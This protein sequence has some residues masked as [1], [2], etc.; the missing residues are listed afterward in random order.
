MKIILYSIFLTLLSFQ[1]FAA[2]NFNC[3]AQQSGVDPIQIQLSDDQMQINILN[4]NHY[5][6][7]LLNR[8]LSN[9]SLLTFEGSISAC[10]D[11]PPGGIPCHAMR[12]VILKMDPTLAN[13]SSV[14]G[15]V[16]L[17]N[18]SFTCSLDM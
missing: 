8:I 3:Q 18:L 11:I 6:G 9:D 7:L 17:D 2:Q 10:P 15:N 13:D 16:E 4:Y 1:V 5:R 12:L 14:S